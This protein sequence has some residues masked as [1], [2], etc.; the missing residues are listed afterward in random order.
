MRGTHE[1]NIGSSYLY[2]RYRR[3]SIITGPDGRWGVVLDV[4]WDDPSISWL[5][6]GDWSQTTRYPADT[7]RISAPYVH[8]YEGIP[9]EVLAKATEVMLTG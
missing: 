2:A 1:D 9:D 8:T 6:D 3:G 4:N 5:T 7:G